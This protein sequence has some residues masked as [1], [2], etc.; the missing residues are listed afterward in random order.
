M[1]FLS[2]KEV[3]KKEINSSSVCTEFYVFYTLLAKF[4]LIKIPLDNKA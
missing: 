4:D 2:T 1:F 3:G